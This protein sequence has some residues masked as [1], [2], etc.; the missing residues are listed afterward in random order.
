MPFSSL[1]PHFQRARA[2]LHEHTGPS[3]HPEQAVQSL[4]QQPYPYQQSITTSSDH[5]TAEGLK[6][7]RA[8]WSHFWSPKHAHFTTVRASPETVHSTNTTPSW[9]GYTLWPF[10]IG[11]EALLEAEAIAPGS[12]TT[13]IHTALEATEKFRVQKG[14]WVGGYSAW[15]YY[16]GNDDVYFDDDAQLA[17]A[18]LRAHELPSTSKPEY[19][20]RAAAIVFFLFSGWDPVEG[21]MRWHVIKKSRNACTTNLSGIAALRLALQGGGGVPVNKLVSF[22]KGCSDWVLEKLSDRESGL[23]VDGTGGGPTWTY[24]TGAAIT[25]LCLL[26]RF[27]SGGSGDKAAVLV[28][29]AY[30]RNKSLYDL[31]N[32]SIENRYW[33]DS[34]FFVQLLIEGLVE[35]IDTFGSQHPYVA[36]KAGQEVKREAEYI[37]THLRDHDDGLYMRNMRLYVLTEKHLE[38]YK[39]ETGQTDRKLEADESERWTE[40][41]PVE[42]RGVCKT[43]LGCGGAARSLLLAGYL[44][45]SE[46]NIQ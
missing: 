18:L 27:G 32:P 46:G 45:N 30:D 19:L 43:L 31:S 22:A 15:E 38:M 33:W 2:F 4:Q 39:R 36:E 11:I 3:S 25:V 8:L 1:K 10:V 13:E 44:Q 29:A 24:N 5:L 41:G 17:I 14:K 37:M 21:G 35:F 20:S 42:K 34:T 7:S 6:L 12:F 40:D 26:S 9:W 23:I 28:A 16:D